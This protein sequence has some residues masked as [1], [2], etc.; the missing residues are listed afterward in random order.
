MPQHFARQL[1]S[2][3]HLS[4]LTSGVSQSH[5]FFFVLTSQTQSLITLTLNQKT[6]AS[7][8]ISLIW[9]LC[10]F[11]KATVRNNHTFIWWFNIM[12]NRIEVTK[13]I[14]KRNTMPYSNPTSGYI[15]KN[16]ISDT[17]FPAALHTIT[18]I[19]KQPVSTDIWRIKIMSHTHN[20]PETYSAIKWK[21]SHLW[22]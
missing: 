22:K 8:L 20:A 15:S 17:M 3:L 12:E 18:K 10:Q 14:K 2:P 9:G 5:L 16:E 19:C 6:K 21:S 13:K 4:R 7:C 1:L 11:P